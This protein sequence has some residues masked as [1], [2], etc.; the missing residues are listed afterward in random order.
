MRVVKSA[1][2]RLSAVGALIAAGLPGAATPAAAASP[3]QSQVFNY[4]GGLQYWY[5][6]PRVGHVRVEAWGAQGLAGAGKSS[7]QVGTVI[8]VSEGRWSGVRGRRR[9]GA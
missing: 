9:A 2:L 4:T 1:L 3:I 8:A 7:G 5:V 6:P